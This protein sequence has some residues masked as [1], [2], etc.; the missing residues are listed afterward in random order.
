VK[1]LLEQGSCACLPRKFAGR[2]L[3]TQPQE[4]RP[5]CVDA[6]EHYRGLS[7]RDKLAHRES[8]LSLE[9]APVFGSASNG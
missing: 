1:V 6:A 7:R 4:A 2:I 3:T 5:I 9:A 8:H